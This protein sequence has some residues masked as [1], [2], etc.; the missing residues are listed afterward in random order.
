VPEIIADNRLKYPNVNFIELDMLS[1]NVPR[2]DLV[3][4]RDCLVHFP[5]DDV[6]RALNNIYEST[7]GYFLSTTFPNHANK[8][9]I[10]MGD[11]RPLNLEDAPFNLPKPL[12][13]INEGLRG[14]CADKSMAVWSI[15]QLG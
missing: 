1:D 6:F 7:S 3:I 12:A 14:D 15:D 5:N 10:E 8:K 9:D 13:I 11:W 2:A 4:V